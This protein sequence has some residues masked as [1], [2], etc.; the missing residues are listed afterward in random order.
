MRSNNWS[1]YVGRKAL[2]LKLALQILEI[3]T[4]S[5][6]LSMASIPKESVNA[7]YTRATLTGRPMLATKPRQYGWPS[8]IPSPWFA[9]AQDKWLIEEL[10]YLQLCRAVR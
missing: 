4:G 1:G 8:R 7:K 10:H 3:V 6:Y 2:K 9:M 5:L